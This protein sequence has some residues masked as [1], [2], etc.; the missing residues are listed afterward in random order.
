MP[1]LLITTF[2]WLERCTFAA[3]VVVLLIVGS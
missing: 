2:S 1:A 3:I